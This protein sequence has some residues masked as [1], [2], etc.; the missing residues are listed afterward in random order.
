MS[1]IMVISTLLGHMTHLMTLPS[2]HD[3]APT[4]SQP[5]GFTQ[6]SPLSSVVVVVGPTA[7]DDSLLQWAGD[8]HDQPGPDLHHASSMS[9][10]H[11]PMIMSVNTLGLL[12]E[13]LHSISKQPR[14]GLV[15][16][17]YMWPAK[18][19]G[20]VTLP[21]SLWSFSRTSVENWSHSQIN[22]AP[23]SLTC[24]VIP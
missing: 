15:Q 20:V 17:F 8:G 1:L 12:T 22:T 3:K 23:I 16:Y 18:R 11:I 4:E 5:G 13:A 19:H 14:F 2:L 7:A 6:S 24:S 10:C 9:Q 21:D